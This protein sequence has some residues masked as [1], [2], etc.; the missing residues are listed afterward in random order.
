MYHS[1]AGKQKDHVLSGFTLKIDR[2]VQNLERRSVTKTV[3]W[4]PVRCS[5][6]VIFAR[7]GHKNLSEQNSHSDQAARYSTYSEKHPPCAKRR[8]RVYDCLSLRFQLARARSREHGTS[9][10]ENLSRQR[11]L[12]TTTAAAT[13]PRPSIS[14]CKIRSQSSQSLRP[15]ATNDRRIRGRKPELYHAT[16]AGWTS[17]GIEWYRLHPYFSAIGTDD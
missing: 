7:F 5:K 6:T 3:T 16:L 9:N 17:L 12:P 14:S 11:E 1:A 15:N 13:A 8:V 10:L 2:K 4:T